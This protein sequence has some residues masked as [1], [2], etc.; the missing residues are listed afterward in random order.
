V[1]D[2]GRPV[3]GIK[4]RLEGAK[5]TATTTDGSGYYAFSDLRAGVSYTITPIG[6][7]MNFTPLSRSFNNLTQDGMADFNGVGERPKIVSDPK[8]GSD[9]KTVSECTE[10]D[11]S[12]ERSNIIATYGP[13]W[14]KAI[15]SER[16]RIIAEIVRDGEVAEATSGRLQAQVSFLQECKVAYVTIRYIWQV[17]TFNQ[18]RPARALN[19]PRQQRLFCGRII[20]GWLCR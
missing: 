17:R 9:S 1:T 15:E 16:P 3:G 4:V 6:A 14:S 8:P 5:A 2:A 11:E 19:I 13:R 18:G 12:R 10:A 7:K 20:G